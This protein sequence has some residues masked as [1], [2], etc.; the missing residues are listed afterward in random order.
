MPTLCGG[1]RQAVGPGGAQSVTQSNRRPRHGHSEQSRHEVAREAGLENGP[2]NGRELAARRRPPRVL[3]VS[4]P[5]RRGSQWRPSQGT[6]HDSHQGHDRADRLALPQ[7]RGAVRLRH[8]GM[9]RPRV[10][11]RHAL[12]DQGRRVALH[13]RRH[14][15]QRV[16]NLGRPR[17]PRGGGAGRD[18]HGRLRSSCRHEALGEAAGAPTGRR[19]VERWAPAAIA[20]WCGRRR[21]AGS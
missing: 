8:E 6:G 2:R 20:W 15:A 9:G 16:R 4:R 10:R 21:S 1:L 12:T 13:S 3:Q 14:E 17:D 18:G 11:G 5:R 19:Q 7:V